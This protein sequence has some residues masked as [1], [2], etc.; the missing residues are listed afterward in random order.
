MGVCAQLLSHVRLFA[1]P[2]T[3]AHQ[4]P[5]FMQFSR[6]EYWS[7]LPFPSPGDLPALRIEPE[8]PALAGR[9][10]TTAP[11]GKPAITIQFNNSPPEYIPSKSWKQELK[12]YPHMHSYSNTVHS[13][14]KVEATQLC[15]D[16]WTGNKTG[17]MHTMA[18]GP[19]WEWS[20]DACYNVDEPWIYYAKWI[21]QT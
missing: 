2:W 9:F 10:F 18:F 16:R 7:G 1:T 14:W 5:V 6:Q 20:T 21:S 4:A 3:V 15:I 12:K 8:S 17:R 13:G 19:T 11:P